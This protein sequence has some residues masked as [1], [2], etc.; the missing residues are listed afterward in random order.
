[1]LLKFDN[2]PSEEMATDKAMELC[3]KAY[4]EFRENK[5]ATVGEAIRTHFLIKTGKTLTFQTMGRLTTEL[6]RRS[7]VG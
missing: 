6:I 1:M 2:G 5:Y 3:K 4:S 7:N